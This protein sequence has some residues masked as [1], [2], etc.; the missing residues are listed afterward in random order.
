M[1]RKEGKY[2]SKRS[3]RMSKENVQRPSNV[4]F[5]FELIEEWSIETNIIRD[6]IIIISSTIA[7]FQPSLRL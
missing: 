2:Y 6:T 7:G 3:I 5:L 4:F 1:T